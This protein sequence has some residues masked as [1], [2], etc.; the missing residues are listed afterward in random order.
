MK[1]GNAKNIKK[2]KTKQKQ[3]K[4]KKKHTCLFTVEKNL[5]SIKKCIHRIESLGPYIL[6]TTSF[7]RI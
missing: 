6:I 3:N 1:R 7:K 2:K 4:T 5:F